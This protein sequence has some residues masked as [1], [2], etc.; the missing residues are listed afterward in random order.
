MK[1][2]LK[3]GASF[4]WQSIME[5]VEVFKRGYIWRIGTGEHVNI[6]ND[7][8]IP[9]SADRKVIT[10]R[11]RTLVTRVCDLMDPVNGTWDEELLRD[12]FWAVDVRR[13]MQ[14]PYIRKPSKISLLGNLT[15]Q[16][17]SLSK[18]LNIFSG[19][20]LSVRMQTG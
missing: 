1:A 19:I 3:N 6:W 16:G 18:W 12:I 15:E 11:N 2:T 20:I 13:I 14:I 17:F 7:P 5:G 9:T 8:W 10:P 4:T